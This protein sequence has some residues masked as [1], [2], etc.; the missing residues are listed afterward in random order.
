MH[1]GRTYPASIILFRDFI[2][3]PVEFA[4]SMVSFERVFE[5]IDLPIEIQEKENAVPLVTVR[6]EIEF[7]H[8]TFKYPDTSNGLLTDV[9]RPYLMENASGVLS[10]E[11]LT[12]TSQSMNGSSQARDLALSD[13]SFTAKPGNLVALVGPSGAGKTTLTYLIPRLV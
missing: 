7:D 4:T 8:V 3:A 6:G 12:K 1:S 2:N 11:A 5:V 10:E 13:I 9:N